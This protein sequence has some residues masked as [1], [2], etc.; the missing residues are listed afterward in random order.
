MFYQHLTPQQFLNLILIEKL[1]LLHSLSKPAAE[2][3]IAK[4]LYPAEVAA[5]E[6]GHI[7]A[8]LA[9]DNIHK[10]KMICFTGGRTSSISYLIVLLSN[11]TFQHQVLK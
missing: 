7:C 9:A 8:C 5:A 3:L 4:N 6:V 11:Q 2:E 10:W 1:S